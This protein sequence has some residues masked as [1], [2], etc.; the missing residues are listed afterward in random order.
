MTQWTL[1]A[2]GK[3][4]APWNN[5]CQMY[6]KRMRSTKITV[7]EI[8]GKQWEKIEKPPSQRWVMWD[9]RGTS[10]SS[11]ELWTAL[12]ALEPHHICFFIGEAD[13]IPQ[14]IM[15]KADAC[16]SLGTMTWPHLWARAMVLEQLYRK[17]LAQKGHPYSF[18]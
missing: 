16:W 10:L 3:V 18:I 12:D 1:Y 2:G 6:L 5:I 14:D 17:T 13:G 7:K 8:T 9:E 4:R 11:P 15:R